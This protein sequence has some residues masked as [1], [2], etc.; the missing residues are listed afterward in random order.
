MY[1]VICALLIFLCSGLC[2]WSAAAAGKHRAASNIG[3]L[4]AV[5][6]A[7]TGSI[8]AFGV[9][10]HNTPLVFTSRWHIPLGSLSLKLDPLS[11][12]FVITILIVVACAAVYG[13]GYL[14]P[15]EGTIR[16]GMTWLWFG[17][18][19]SSMVVVCCANNALLFLVAWEIMALSSFFLVIFESHKETTRKASWIYMTATYLGTAMLLPMFLLMGSTSG[20]LDF[21][22]FNLH[23]NPH[24]A[25]VC[26]I[27]ALIGF[28]TKAGI[29]PFHIWLPEAHPAA[30]T[31][32]SAI[33]SGVMIKTGIYALLRIMTFTGVPH[34]W[35]GLL[36]LIVGAFTAVPGVVFALA[37]N[38]LKRMLAYC[39]VENIGVIVMGMGIGSI[40]MS[41]GN[42]TVAILG[43][44]GALLHVLNHALFKSLLFM[45][46]GAI[47]GKTHTLEMN[48]LGGLLKK[49][50]VTGAVFCIGAIAVSAL[51]PLN[52]F[53]SEWMLYNASFIGIV[54]GT[55]HLM[56]PLVLAVGVLALTG[57]LTAV[58]FTRAFGCVWLGN[59]RA[60]SSVVDSDVPAEMLVPMIALAG[61]CSLL[62]V[63]ALFIAGHIAPAVVLITGGSA[64]PAALSIIATVKIVGYMSVLLIIVCSVVFGI[65]ALLLRKQTKA[66]A[67]TWD[68]G[69]HAGTSKMQY[70]AS[71]FSQPVT[72]QFSFLL[73]TKKSGKMPKGYFPGRAGLE[74]QTSDMGNE[75]LYQPL[76]AFITSLLGRFRVL[77]QGSIQLYVFYLVIVLVLLLFWRLK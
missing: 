31:H 52:G 4:G 1:L 44:G 23:V 69:Y 37:Q 25:D 74:T 55:M 15:Y 51:P 70:T 5:V 61:L 56:I 11:A 47:Y 46:A 3:S 57:G 65:R 76:F 6:A 20:S 8:P 38:N 13:A 27:L 62:G 30:P 58:C 21:A 17:I 53:I 19:A 29:V 63:G 73:N 68:C 49:M 77:Q 72:E 24:L 59:P 41:F 39:S 26:F 10:W 48:M 18:L 16:T 34:L 45:G 75:R 9:L 32:V 40:G 22:T 7:I 14:R 60:A 2:A 64:I 54:S 33:M 66:A 71:S 12:F 35:W 50:P 36:L 28:G 67:P 43:F 42:T